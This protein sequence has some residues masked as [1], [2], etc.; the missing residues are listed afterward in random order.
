MDATIAYNTILGLL[1]NSPSLGLRPNFFNL[2]ELRLHYARALKKVPCPQSAINGWS[3]AVLAP[4]MYALID[5]QRFH[6]N[7]TALPIPKFPTCFVQNEDD[8][9]GVKIPYTREEIFTITAT[10][11]R[12]KHY[13]DTGTNVCRAVFN[14][15]DAH[16][17][18]EFKSPP[19]NAQG[20]TGWNSTMLPNDIFDQLMLIYGKPT[21]DAVR[22]NNLM[23]YSMYNP[24][25]P[26]EVLFKRLLDCQEIAIVAKVPFTVKQLLVN[27]ERCR[28]LHLHRFIRARYGRLGAKATSRS[29]IFQLTPFHPSRVS[30]S[31]HVRNRHRFH[32]RLRVKQSLCWFIHGRRCIRR[33]HSRIYRRVNK[34][35]HGKSLRVSDDTI[36]SFERRKYYRFQ[37]SNTA[38]G[39]K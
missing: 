14:S 38:C 2:R 23:F 36:V 35:S 26:P 39:C 16:V 22:Q 20:T 7:I 11:A 32:R 5:T 19:T 27:R 17:G 18:D 29:N 12:H 24:K 8:T 25:D 1:A 33:W 6:W 37:R 4:A 28:P 21:P 13:Y 3:G 34:H 10:H 31:P 15:L 30:T 9:N